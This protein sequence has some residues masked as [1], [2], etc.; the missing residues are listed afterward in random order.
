MQRIK[1]LKQHKLKVPRYDTFIANI[2]KDAVERK[3]KSKL[4]I[5]LRPER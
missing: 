4:I 3:D 2:V 5:I 1:H